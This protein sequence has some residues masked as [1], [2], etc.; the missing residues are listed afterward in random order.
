MQDDRIK[1]I[2]KRCRMTMNGIVSAGMRRRGLDYKLNFGLSVPQIRNLSK[3]YQ[4][5]AELAEMLWREDIRELKILAT[6]L[7]PVDEFSRD[8]AADW[9]SE[10]P[11]QEIREQVCANLFQ[12]LP[13]AG[14]IALEW[15]DSSET[16]IATTGYW[17]LVR[18]FLAKK[19]GH[20]LLT[21]SL[22]TVWEDIISEDIFLRNA[23]LLALKHIGR[24]SEYLA[25]FILR[26]LSIYRGDTDLIKREAFD[27][28]AFEFDYFFKK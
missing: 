3:R 12:D 26:K 13:Y 18:L 27:S 1:D 25:D 10:I 5:E 14:P 8:R 28:A 20:I 7:Y 16:E 4:P 6:L 9:V 23:S 17:L 24:Q 15:A 21:D 19:I 11:N 22:S 2:R